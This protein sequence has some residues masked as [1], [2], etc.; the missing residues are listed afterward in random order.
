MVASISSRALIERYELLLLDAFGVL[1]HS[2]GPMPGAAAFLEAVRAAGKR[3]LVVTNDASRLPETAVARLRGFGFP[4]DL[5]HIVSSGMLIEPCFRE[6][7]LGGARCLVLGPEDSVEHVRRAG[8]EIVPCAEDGEYDAVLV[9]DDAGYPFLGALDATITAL[10]R[11]IDRG[12]VPALILPNPDI[13]YPRGEDAFG[14]TAGAAAML[15]EAA[16]ARRYPDRELCFERLGK[17]HPPLFRAALERGGGGPAVMVG[18]QL[19]TDIAGANRA[20]IDSAL[21]T[22]GVSGRVPESGEAAPTWMLESFEL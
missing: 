20:G 11:L 13:I 16:L 1:V 4:V 10:F 18:D 22:F 15:I 2:G 8:G 21:V 7:G 9:C 5:E 19:E 12:R 17:P 3:Y 14:F 6:R